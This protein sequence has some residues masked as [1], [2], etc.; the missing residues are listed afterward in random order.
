MS[1]QRVEELEHRSDKTWPDAE[2]RLRS[3]S[4]RGSAGDP[5]QR[6]AVFA[7]VGSRAREQVRAAVNV[8]VTVS[9]A[10]EQSLVQL[11]TRNEIRQHDGARLR[12][13]VFYGANEMMR[14]SAGRQNDEPMAG[15]VRGAGGAETDERA[16]EGPHIR[17]PHE[18]RRAGCNHW[19]RG[20]SSS[21]RMSVWTRVIISSAPAADD[22]A[23]HA[24]ATSPDEMAL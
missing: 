23:C 17:R 18:S 22:E 1:L 16:S 2:R 20:G 19:S 14:R 11:V 10:F 24:V 13:P 7:R 12:H 15:I 21:A 6:L 3:R 4:N 8:R 5:E 9:N